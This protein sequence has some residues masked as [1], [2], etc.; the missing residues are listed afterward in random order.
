MSLKKKEIAVG[1]IINENISELKPLMKDKGIN[2]KAE[3][4]PPCNRIKLLCDP[5]RISQVIGNLVRNSVD[6]VED[7]VGRITIRVELNENERVTNK[8]KQDYDSAGQVVITV[9]DNGPGIPRD[10]AENLFKKFYQIDTTLTRK[11]GGTGLGLAISRGIVE[12]HGG[13]IWVDLEQNNGASIKFTLPIAS[14]NS[15]QTNN[16]K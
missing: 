13:T 1:D 3:V 15:K 6:F 16:N 2:F 12:A 9:E 7:K 14:T 8:L 11:H 4:R 5:R 10:K